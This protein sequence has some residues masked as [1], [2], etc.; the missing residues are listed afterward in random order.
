M[1]TRIVRLTVLLAGMSVVLFGIPLAI[2]AAQY[3]ISQEHGELERIAD[4]AAIAAGDGLTATTRSATTLDPTVQITMVDGA[5]PAGS[6]S[7]PLDP[8]TAAALTG[9]AATG[10]V[11]GQIAAAAPVTD[12]DQVVGAVLATTA[13]GPVY[14]RIALT[15][16][17][18]AGLAAAAV[19]IAWLLARRQARRLTAPLQDLS[20]AA[21]R[22]GTGDFG[23]RTRLAG[24]TEIDL[25]GESVN[26]T[27]ARL[28][29]MVD[30]ERAFA[31]DASHQLRTPLTG[32]RLELESALTAPD[33]V[34]RAAIVSALEAAERLQ[35][36]V[37]QLLAL[38]RTAPVIQALEVTE[39]LEQ[40]D[41]RWHPQLATRGRPLR[42]AVIGQ[43]Q[44]HGSAAAV[45]QILDV[46]I[47][48][49]DR[50]GT[51]EIVVN[52]RELA[53]GA[54][55][56]VSDDGPGPSDDAAATHSGQV[57]G[58]SGHGRGLPLARRLAHAQGGRLVLSQRRPP[59]FSL[60]LLGHPLGP[61]P[62]SRTHLR[63]RRIT[64]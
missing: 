57:N 32:L 26:R 38:A 42:L 25:V 24:V 58:A 30:R 47:D 53:D 23:V 28:G 61:G 4:A 19:T 46:L 43:P 20:R 18:M 40:I 15:W 55:I 37:D 56:E 1:R 6:G 10:T 8:L 36:T 50:H 9:V 11:N 7:G 41:R 60:L 31:A 34:P 45:N 44:P 54:A 49:A 5:T 16:L 63:T 29:A 64:P 13:A 35:V 21:E 33:A 27:A 51:G 59:T 62:R 14:L 39:L 48:N 2:A 17:A 3:L 12:G 52:I 22:L